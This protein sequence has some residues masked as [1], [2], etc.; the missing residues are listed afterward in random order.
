MEGHKN[1]TNEVDDSHKLLAIGI[2][3]KS[4]L[5]LQGKGDSKANVPILSIDD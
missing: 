1:L 5:E 3:N 4:F 2:A